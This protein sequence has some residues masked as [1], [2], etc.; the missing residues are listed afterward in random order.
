MSDVLP[1][2]SELRLAMEHE[3]D[4]ELREL[5]LRFAQGKPLPCNSRHPEMTLLYCARTKAAVEILSATDP[6]MWRV[7]FSLRGPFTQHPEYAVQKICRDCKDVETA[8]RAMELAAQHGGYHVCHLICA[9]DSRSI[10]VL[11]F[12]I[13]EDARRLNLNIADSSEFLS[14]A[15]DNDSSVEIPRFAVN[16]VSQEALTNW[17]GQDNFLWSLCH[18][19][20]YEGDECDGVEHLVSLVQR[21]MAIPDL[22]LPAFPGFSGFQ[23]HMLERLRRVVARLISRTSFETLH[24]FLEIAARCVEEGSNCMHVAA[25]CCLDDNALSY[26]VQKCPSAFLSSKNKDRE[27][28]LHSAQIYG[29]DRA[30]ALFSLHAKIGA[31]PSWSELLLAVTEKKDNE[32]RELCLRFPRRIPLP[33]DPHNS[34]LTLLHKAQTK[35][36]V[37]ILIECDRSVWGV[38]VG[39]SR[40]RPPHN[41]PIREMC[42]SCSDVETAEYAARLWWEKT[43]QEPLM[44]SEMVSETLRIP[45][46]MSDSLGTCLLED[47]LWN[48]SSPAVVRFFIN[49]IPKEALTTWVSEG[50]LWRVLSDVEWN[51]GPAGPAAFLVEKVLST[52]TRTV[53][54]G[55]K[56]TTRFVDLPLSHPDILDMHTFIRTGSKRIRR[57]V[58]AL[59][60]ALSAKASSMEP[61][62]QFLEAIVKAS[63]LGWNVMHAAAVFCS[64]AKAL[65]Y[66]QTKCN[67]AGDFLAADITNRE[68]PLH[69]AARFGNA[70]A[71]SF[72]AQHAPNLLSESSNR[73][74]QQPLLLA[75][76]CGAESVIREVVG[77]N[78]ERAELLSM[79][80]SSGGNIFLVLLASG[81]LTASGVEWFQQVCPQCLQATDWMGNTTLHV[82][83]VTSASKMPTVSGQ[84]LVDVHRLLF[85]YCRS[86]VHAMN[87]KGESI[88]SLLASIPNVPE[89]IR[90]FYSSQ[91]ETTML[92]YDDTLS[93]TA[94]ALANSRDVILPKLAEA[95]TFHDEATAAS[96]EGIIAQCCDE[97]VECEKHIALVPPAAVHVTSTFL[98]DYKSR[99][100]QLK[101]LAGKVAEGYFSFAGEMS[102]R[103]Q[104][105]SRL[106]S[107]SLA[108][109]SVA[110]LENMRRQIEACQT[111][112]E[113]FRSIPELL[114]VLRQQL[115]QGKSM[116]S[117]QEILCKRLELRRLELAQ[118][119]LDEVDVDASVDVDEAETDPPR[120]FLA[121]ERRTRAPLSVAPTSSQVLALEE[122]IEQNRV[123]LRSL[124]QQQQTNI[125]RLL[126]VEDLLPRD[127]SSL[128]SEM[129]R[130]DLGPLWAEFS[131][132]RMLSDFRGVERLAGQDHI[133]NATYNGTSFVLKRLHMLTEGIEQVINTELRIRKRVRH[134]HVLSPEVGFVDDVYVYL[135]FR[136]LETTLATWLKENSPGAKPIVI[137]LAKAASGIAALH[138][139]GVVHGD[140]KPENILLDVKTLDPVIADFAESYLRVQTRTVTR[141]TLRYCPAEFLEKG[142]AEYRPHESHDSYSFG[143]M[144]SD[145]SEMRSII[146]D[147]TI[148]ELL[149][150]IGA[151]MKHKDPALRTS[152]KDCAKAL[153]EA[154]AIVIEAP[155]L[156]V[157]QFWQSNDLS[158]LKQIPDPN[159][160][161]VCRS[162]WPAEV[163]K[164]I[165]HFERVESGLLFQQFS[166]ECQKVA[167][168]H[169]GTVPA[170]PPSLRFADV[171]PGLAHDPLGTNVR[172]LLHGTTKKRASSIT[173]GGFDPSYSG[174]SAGSVFGAGCYFTDNFTKAM[175]Y[176]KGALIVALVVLGDPQIGL[177]AGQVGNKLRRPPEGKD[178]LVARNGGQTAAQEILVYSVTKAYPQFIVLLKD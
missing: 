106:E 15:L 131:D 175:S 159:F 119:E 9:R 114:R 36:A 123:K 82:A 143:V 69:I 23:M 85:T 26:L 136:K 171:L 116:R 3:S 5:C 77:K 54:A 88:A 38:A 18:A 11:K 89:D 151:A 62:R 112:L 178:S 21:I 167:K 146:E 13:S 170:F 72:F 122:E 94:Q 165:S 129:R 8:R 141:T 157:P 95:I 161:R 111:R 156:S 128:I 60:A 68:T 109:D 28:P 84:G 97:L 37:D 104:E 67:S 110:V 6:T 177:P 90:L 162:H 7:K 173:V 166:F 168:K 61:V 163:F 103:A 150:R 73:F 50:K 134:P 120:K 29:N 20:D 147:Q 74:G 14:A 42:R 99:A 19:Q 149:L 91:I 174:E 133:W 79:Q 125:R 4:S 93:R 154:V 172:F 47:V 124:M 105:L 35:A 118:H 115:S 169:N 70:P 55:P 30:A 71:A 32:L 22:E 40:P 57:V 1:T 75:A 137:V 153:Q 27:Q 53:V 144:L 140:V 126:R 83:L 138:A 65:D 100:D 76:T 148:R 176:A 130:H 155:V 164:Q 48:S 46:A 142:G 64:D 66:I 135:Q 51:S 25:A 45:L 49:M 43:A 132:G 117:R 44:V 101:E 33:R 81:S 158:V 39:S 31:L 16:Y 86:L 96:A 87:A 145:I 127:A 12:V 17:V 113:A 56:R 107:D 139:N 92:R 121:T 2:W 108:A 80:G 102:A 52:T 24:K 160:E 63:K 10:D 98:T 78:L 41:H 58:S 152:M 34:A 59:V